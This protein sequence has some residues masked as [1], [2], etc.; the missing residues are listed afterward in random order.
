MNLVNSLRILFFL[1]VIYPHEIRMAGEVTRNQGYDYGPP[2]LTLASGGEVG[3]PTQISPP[4]TL[5]PFHKQTL[6]S[7]PFEKL[8]AAQDSSERRWI[9]KESKQPGATKEKDS[10]LEVIEK[11]KLDMTVKQA[12]GKAQHVMG[13][14]TSMMRPVMG[15]KPK[16][17]L[18]V[19]KN[20]GP[21]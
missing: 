5:R 9:E 13:P 16:I 19:G 8:T 10:E 3:S 18:H 6:T 1:L 15:E 20:K 12:V 7:L 14:L 4:D 2:T 11:I 21:A 17:P